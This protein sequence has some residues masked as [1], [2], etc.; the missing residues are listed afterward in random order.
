M[1]EFYKRDPSLELTWPPGTHPVEQSRLW[2][3]VEL[4]NWQ[5]DV[6][7]AVALPHS[8]VIYSTNNES[9]KTSTL[10]KVFILSCMARFP[11]C[12]AYV[13]SASERQVKEQ[14]FEKYLF[15]M[16]QRFRS[17]GWTATKDP[18]KLSMPNGSTCLCYV[19]K[20]A[21]NVEGMHGD[22]DVKDGKPYYRP[23]VYGMDEAKGTKD[24]I[25]EAVRRI[26]PDFLLCQSTPGARGGFF[27]RGINPD[28]L[29]RR[30]A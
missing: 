23:C 1:T 15:P 22:W 13:T 27:Y 24:E 5:I 30:V 7:N 16:A 19:C 2:T 6:L 26:D 12:F 29:N 18:M 11:G 8:R 25:H 10:M 28:E 17:Y 9:G 21:K 4:Y 20:D 3:P 14:F